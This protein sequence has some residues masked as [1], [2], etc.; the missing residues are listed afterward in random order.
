MADFSA[1]TAT[2]RVEKAFGSTPGVR[3]LLVKH[4]IQDATS[5]GYLSFAALEMTTA[6]AL[7]HVTAV[8]I[9]TAVRL[10]NEVTVACTAH[11]LETGDLAVIRGIL[12]DGA[13]DFN[14]SFVVTSTA[15]ANT[16]TYDQTG[17]DDN[18]G[19]VGACYRIKRVPLTVDGHNIKT[20]AQ[21]SSYF[22]RV[23]LPNGPIEVT[24]NVTD[25][26]H[27]V[28]TEDIVGGQGPSRLS[29][30]PYWHKS[31]TPTVPE[32][33]DENNPL[34]VQIRTASGAAALP[35]NEFSVSDTIVRPANTTAYAAQKAVNCS[36]T[37]TAGSYATKTVTL[38][39]NGHPLAVGDRITVSGINNAYT[40]TNVDGDWV[41]SAKATNTFSFVV[42]D[43]PTGVTPASG[44]V[45]AAVAKCLRFNVARAVGTG[46]LLLRASL[47]CQGV[48]M[49]GPFRLYL[50]KAQQTAL[51]DQ[52]T[53]TVLQANTTN[54]LARMDFYPET[55]GTGSD[56]T[57]A[58]VDST[59]YLK[60][61]T[62]DTYLYGRLVAEGASTPVAS[63]TITVKLAGV[64]Y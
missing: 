58:E 44:S 54:R 55:E 52:A 43:T 24:L 64:Q 53:F 5:G 42:T 46:V 11:G 35:A 31:A 60:A 23:S 56:V 48:A 45:A 59:V 10:T 28:W 41:V 2:A 15:D 40:W 3:Q 16:F 33:V 20:T 39:S 13:D 25:G 51:V 29:A 19:T 47:A 17:D 14:G 18:T 22:S 63:A 49:T 50:Y 12:Y 4:Y 9:T 37:V 38:T 8:P 6:Q 7:K 57:F 21:S 27:T 34:P 26:T 61:D 32:D 30:R 62:A 36:L 1:A